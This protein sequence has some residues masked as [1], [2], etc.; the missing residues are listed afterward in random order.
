MS[1][2]A[3]IYPPLGLTIT[4]GDLELRLPTDDDLPGLVEL[5]R[6]GIHP[7]DQMPFQTPWTRQSGPAAEAGLVENAGRSRSATPQQWLLGFLVLQDGQ[8]VG[9]QNLKASDFLV[10]KQVSSGSWLGMAHQG[11]GI[12][13]RMRA[14][15]LCLAFDHLGAEVATSS[16]FADNP[17]SLAVSR[18]L[19]Y[20]DNGREREARDG[21]WVWDQKFL[22]LEPDF[23]RPGEQVTVQGV[24]R[25]REFIGLN[26]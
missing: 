2:L 25:F 24:Q 4:M 3:E 20:R 23:I 11:R 15:T 13:T 9:R 16:A 26:A 14:M 1:T 18:K 6:G 22:L 12:G 5:T 8:P 7:A 10:T 21:E 17:A 19:G